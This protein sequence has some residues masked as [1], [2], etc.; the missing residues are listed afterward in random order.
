[1]ANT[2]ISALPASTIPLA[3]T[4]VLP[5]VQSG[6][7]K[8]VSVANLTSGRAVDVLSMSVATNGY[9][10][11]NTNAYYV[12]SGFA[13]YITGTAKNG[14]SSINFYTNSTLRMQVA[15]TSGN[16]TLNT[17]NLVQGTSG[18][19]IN[20]TANTP[21]A[22]MTSQLL[23]WYEEGTWTPA[24]G[25]GLTVVGAFSSGG[26]YTR[27]GRQVTITGFVKG[28]TSIAVNAATQITNNLPYTSNDS[29]YGAMG[30]DNLTVSGVVITSAAILYS[31]N[32]I[33]ATPS[34]GFSVTY[35]V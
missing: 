34:I 19:G 24:Q 3:G 15:T 18:N 30:N 2:K 5:I 6:A 28:A 23:N 31:N 20:F 8:Q 32:S 1:M 27:V 25:S 16:V 9:P 35:T 4:E 22:G 14:F 26:K 33:G 12:D 11:L 17:G 10:Y 29:Y 21:K 13:A 7:T